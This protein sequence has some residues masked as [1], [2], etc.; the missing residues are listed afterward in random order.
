MHGANINKKKLNLLIYL[1]IYS[2][3]QS[4]SSEG[5]RFSASQEIPNFLWNQKFITAL[6]GAATSPYPEPDW[7]ST[8]HQIPLP[9]D[10]S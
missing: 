4:S 6:I 2:M 5:N 1:L 8:C 10:P 9:E 7:A 3:E